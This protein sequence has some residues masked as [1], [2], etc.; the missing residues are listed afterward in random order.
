L[1]EYNMYNMAPDLARLRAEE[2]IKRGL[3]SQRYYLDFAESKIINGMTRPVSLRTQIRELK[4]AIQDAV[5]KI[6][7]R[8]LGLLRSRPC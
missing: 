6:Q 2:E 3:E 1:N 8:I 5:D 7:C 4:W